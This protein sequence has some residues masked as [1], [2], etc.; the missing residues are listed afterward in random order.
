MYL[1]CKQCYR[2]CKVTKN[3]KVE[4]LWVR[5]MKDSGVEWIGDIPE[6]WDVH[7]VK[8]AFSEVKNKNYDGKEKN[9]LKFT[10]GEIVKKENFKADEDEYIA[11]TILNYTVVNP[12]TIM[13]NGLNLNYDLKSLR[14]GIVPERGIITSAYLA[15]EPDEQKIYPQYAN[16]LF[17]GYESKMA[18]HNMGVGIRLTLGYKEFKR[19]PILVPPL[20]EQYKIAGFLKLKCT[21]IDNAI[22]KTT[23][24][25]EEYKKLKQSII[26]KAV[27]KGIR[28]N[29]PMKDSG[30]E[31][32]GEIPS[33]WKIEKIKYVAL[34]SPPCDKTGILVDTVV[35]YL[36]MECVK[37]G[38]YISN[39]KEF[40]KLSTSLNEFQDGDIIM[41]K[42]TPCFENGNIAI[43]EGIESG[44]GVGSSELFVYRPTRIVGKFLFYWLRNSFFM[45]MGCATMTGTG[46]LKRVNPY[47]VRNCEIHYPPEKEQEEIVAYLDEKCNEIDNI[48]SRKQQLI[49]ELEAYKKSLIYEYVTGKKEVV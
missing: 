10:N 31:W 14:V 19:Q 20:Y 16:L 38:K 6:N 4:V 9:A 13:I 25:I 34:F 33:D 3:F 48:T 15:L 27:T 39:T 49:T 12:N 44:Y 37:N 22:S 43:L 35:T 24:S 23:A 26:T 18:L 28:G 41:A 8:Y 45:D 46:G 1:L 2:L 32:I 5:P 47:Y 11:D 21:E 40:G 36:P 17:K 29:R 7:F 42:V 30:I